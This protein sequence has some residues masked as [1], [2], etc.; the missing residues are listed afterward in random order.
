[1][2]DRQVERLAYEFRHAPAMAVFVIALVA[3]QAN[4]PARAGNAFE[5]GE[6]LLRCVSGKVCL[7][8]AKEV[9]EMA[10]AGGLPP[11][12]GCAETA[13]VQ[14]ADAFF[15]ERGR[16]LP[17]GEAGSARSRNRPH[18]DQEADPRPP[19]FGQHR[20]LGGVLVTDG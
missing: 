10:A 12:G 17:L 3:H 1:M 11:G 16:E 18:V 9:V 4:T 20:S 6:F 19:Q 13:Q 8:D 14:V 5:L 15:V 2:L 7:V